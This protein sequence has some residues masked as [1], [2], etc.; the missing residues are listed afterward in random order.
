MNALA[1]RHFGRGIDCF[2]LD[3]HTLRIRFACARGDFDRV[4]LCY[5]LNKYAWDRERT[6]C[7]MPLWGRGT[8]LDYYE[9]DISGEDTRLCY[10]FILHKGKRKWYF[11]EEGLSRQYDFA[12]A[13]YS[14]FQYPF[15]HACDV[16]R[17]VS[18]A[19][20]AVMYQIFPERFAKGLPEGEKG[21]VNAKWTDVPKPDSYFG[22]D[23]TGIKEHLDY[24][25]DLGISC[26]YLNPIHPARSNHKYNV[27]DYTDVDARFGGKEAFRSL[28][29]AAHE[30]GMRV[31]LDGVFNHCSWDWPPFR[32]CIE[33]GKESPYWDWFFIDG[34]RVDIKKPNYLTFAACPDLP[35]LNTGNEKVI[36]YFCE[37]GALWVR[38]FDI[39]GWRLDVMDEAS[40]T[41][42]RSFRR[43]VKAAKPD[44]LIL[45]E[46]WHDSSAWLRGDELDGVM[47]YGLTKA[48]MDYLVLGILDAAGMADRLMMLF[49]RTSSASAR[50][51]MNLIGS[52]DTDRFLTL[53]GGNK[54]KLCLAFAILFFYVGIPCVYY[55]DEVGMQGGY[56]P[57]CRGGFPW[58]K[59]RQDAMLHDTVKRLAKIK[60]S[61]A[62][63]GD[64][65]RISAEGNVLHIARPGAELWV[66]A[67]LEEAPYTDGTQM[68]SLDACSYVISLRP[69]RSENS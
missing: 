1:I 15:V 66:N 8:S 49:E 4:E 64:R 52:H 11:S 26:L 54:K 38:D 59:D 53:L 12:H 37:I 56:D 33:K 9:K 48:L 61:G 30:R 28:V 40:E 10:L 13:Y 17:V 16:H 21:Y 42:L 41:F 65:I 51:M 2:P 25:Q 34:S 46:S 20:T 39:D 27:M 55:G 7:D 44:A 57:L 62:L 19:D 47:N 60:R 32:D 31:L 68:R 69:E 14:F 63:K 50:M 36:A 29:R 23:L 58:E 3:T 67:S 18:W 22:G 6:I 35:K 5:C 24:L 45:G 43:A